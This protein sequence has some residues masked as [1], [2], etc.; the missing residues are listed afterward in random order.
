VFSQ[1]FYPFID[2]V[3]QWLF[4]HAR[5]ALEKKAIFVTPYILEIYSQD[6]AYCL[7]LSYFRDLKPRTISSQEA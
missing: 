6:Q 4:L 2:L 3:R 7:R 5:P 1:V